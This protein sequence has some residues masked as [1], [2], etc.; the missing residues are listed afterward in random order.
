M[1][2][3]DFCSRFPLEQ[4]VPKE[5]DLDCIKHINFSNE[6][7]IDFNDIAKHTK[8]DSFL[9]Q[10]MTFIRKGWP[11]K[12][13]KHFANIFAN[14]CDLEINE[15]CLIYQD[16]V[17]I[18]QQLQSEMLRL[19]HASHAGIVKMKQLARRSV[20]WYGINADIENFVRECDACASMAVHP[21]QKI[22]SKWTPSS[23]PFGRV[24]I[25]FFYFKHHVF[26]LIVDSY[27]KWVEVE[28]MKNGTACTQVIR[29]L[30]A[31][32]ARF[33]FPDILVSDNGPPFNSHDFKTF[34]ERQGIRVL[35]SPPYNPASNG[36]AERLVLT[37]KDVLK[38]LLLDP[39]Y[40]H[41][42]LV[43]LISLFLINFRNNT[44]T[45]DGFFPSQKVLAYTPKMLIDLINPKRH[46]NSNTVP[47]TNN[48]NRNDDIF[49]R[50]NDGL[51]KEVHNDP[52]DSL[53]AGDALWYKNNNPHHQAKWIKAH[54]LKRMCKN[55]LQITIGSGLTTTAHRSQI[56]I[57]NDR[58]G[59]SASWKEP[60]HRIS[61]I[62]KGR[63]ERVWRSMASHGVRR[64]NERIISKRISFILTF[65]K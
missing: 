36:Q 18:P 12:I 51:S 47:Q 13:D 6:C 34:L 38:K 10:I 24:H 4:S 44:M 50:S 7:P 14:Q 31:Y 57:V 41:L 60:D 45:M 52:L 22:E 11:S 29:K 28:W 26:L 21:K 54:F 59:K 9:Q 25:D 17:I 37:V 8:T 1:G 55:V 53:M 27:S 39:E 63:V 64:G 49:V 16:R 58:D 19:L 43:D 20:Y 30:L 32:F 35:N 3:A 5:L 15:D 62:G 65:K 40:L 33:G 56:K 46:S 23:R 61:R 48:V 42:E 2:N